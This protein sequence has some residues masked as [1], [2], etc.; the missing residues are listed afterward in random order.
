MLANCLCWAY[1][2]FRLSE[3]PHFP[4]II[5]AETPIWA[6]SIFRLSGAPHFPL[7]SWC[8]LKMKTAICPNKPY[9][10]IFPLGKGCLSK[11]KNAIYPSHCLNSPLRQICAKSCTRF[12]PF[13][14]PEN[15]LALIKDY[16]KSGRNSLLRP[17][18]MRLT[19]QIKTLSTF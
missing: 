10:T 3:A 6:Y 9:L 19:L 17:D 13:D 2:I 16:C 1:S 8:L 14:L 5:A 15:S 4:L 7:F 18:S 12:L 11:M